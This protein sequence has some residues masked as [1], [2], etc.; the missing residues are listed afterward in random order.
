MSTDNS[1]NRLLSVVCHGC[2]FFGVSMVT[3]AIPIVALF[4]SNDETVRANAKESINFHLNIWFWAAVIGGIYGF[5][6]WITFGLL[7]LVLFPLVAFGF[8]WHAWWSIVAVIHALS[9][10]EPYRYPFILRIL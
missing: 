7:G 1:K 9:S 4:L 8:L 3:I 10:S 6:A 5:L 2:T